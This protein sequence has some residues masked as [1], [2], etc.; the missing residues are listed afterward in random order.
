VSIYVMRHAPSR[1]NSDDPKKE[2]IRG[3]GDIGLSPEGEQIA[4]GAADAFQ[5]VPLA[6][7]FTSDLPRAKETAEIVAKELGSIPVIADRTLRTWNVGDITGEPVSTAKPQ[8]DDLQHTHPGKSAPNGESYA[9]FYARWGKIVEQLRHLNTKQN[10][11]VVVHGRQVYALPNLLHGTGP[12][13]VPTHG[14]P[15]PGDVLSINEQSKRIQY[16]HRAGTKAAVTA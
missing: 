6:M 10:F 4:K 1:H 16:V 13:G 14:A 5:H 12:R 15:D 11:L 7:I 3:W 8:L 9:D 2:R